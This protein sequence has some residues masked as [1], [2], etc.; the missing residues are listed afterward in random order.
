MGALAQLGAFL[1]LKSPKA[2][3][4]MFRASLIALLLVPAVTAQTTCTSDADCSGTVPT[5]C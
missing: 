2:I 5:V 4:K 1:T 3:R